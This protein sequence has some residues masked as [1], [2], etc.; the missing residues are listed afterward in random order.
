MELYQN[1]EKYYTDIDNILNKI[2]EY[3]VAIIPN[4]L[5]T[6][7][8]DNNFNKMCE[9]FNYITQNWDI[10]LNIKNPETY[11]QFWNLFPMHSMLIQHWNAGHSQYVWDIRQ[12]EEIINI[13]AKIWDCKND[14]LLVS[15]DGISFHLP[16]ET[17][18]RGWFRNLWLH[19]DQ[20]FT[21]NE[22]ECVQGFITLRDINEGDATFC[23]IEKSNN[24]HK[25]FAEKFE[26][27]DK[28]DWCKLTDDE[29][30]Y[31]YQLGCE[32]KRIKAPKGSLILWDSR[33]IHCGVE[34]L[35][36]RLVPNFRSIVYLCYMPRYKS[37]EKQ[38]QKKIKAFENL[39]MTT[40]WP[41]NIKLFPK[42]PRTYGNELKEI[43]KID[44]PII[45]NI[46]RNL[47]GFK[48]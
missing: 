40:H 41:C 34:P 43:K 15:F 20:S 10:P 46:G 16:P 36:N 4:V 5:N 3:G 39:R 24:F 8:C 13:F 45:N 2:N 6:E 19:C 42:N 21:R 1:S 32:L 12:N 33:T 31:Y 7:E 25:E 47:I 28:K 27:K 30:S 44:F 22:F 9:Y 17:T 48:N 26:K 38:I 23:F 11:R 18:N 37:T 29:I 14:E 35:K